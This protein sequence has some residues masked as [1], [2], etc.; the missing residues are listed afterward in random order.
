VSRAPQS[1]ACRGV[2]GEWL[3]VCR[4]WVV[5]SGGEWW[6]VGSMKRRK[7]RRSIEPHQRGVGQ[8]TLLLKAN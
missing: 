8:R 5:S 4:G 3:V 6:G 7:R 1:P 2:V